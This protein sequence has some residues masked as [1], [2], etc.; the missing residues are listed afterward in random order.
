M[1][2]GRACVMPR[3]VSWTSALNVVAPVRSLK[4]PAKLIVGW[5][6]A[7]RKSALRRCSSRAGSPVQMAVAL[8]S[9]ANVASRLR[10]QSSSSWPWM[11]LNKPRTQVT[12]M[13]RALNSASV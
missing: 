13:W 4:R 12:I 9:P 6:A 8:I 2:S 11:S 10:S 3:I 7:S 1:S 5:F